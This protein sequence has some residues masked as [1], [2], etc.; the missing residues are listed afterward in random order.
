MIAKKSIR[1]ALF[2]LSFFATVYAAHAQVR[3]V[4]SI[5]PV[6]SLVS[7]VMQ[8][9]G[10]PEL[11]V[12]G[13]GSPHAYA[14]RP[15][16]ASAMQKAQVV[17]W[18]SEN[19]ER[20]LEGPIK[21]LAGRARVVELA[22]APGVTTRT[23]REGGIWEKHGHKEA[24]HRKAA[25]GKDNDHD[26]HDHGRIDSHMWVDPVN[27]KAYVTAI[28]A[29]LAAAD[30]GNAALYR[31]N[32]TAVQAR[33]DALQSEM[34]ATLAPVKAKGFIVFHDAFQYLEKRFGLKGVGS[35]SLG[36]ARAPGAR[37]LRD[38][39]SRLKASG[40]VCVFS[41]P[42]FEPRL[43]QTVIEGMP[44]KTG[45]LDP[46]GAALG[47]GPDLYFMMMRNNARALRA[48]LAS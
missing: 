1:T 14:M 48:C 46:L 25:H 10:K 32:A 30:P 24:A 27:A 19:L 7:A 29:A 26:G 15:S 38:I 12:Q 8:G 16:D 4:A 44:I 31:K 20:F 39:R 34:S 11:I 37:R 47:N 3:V 43:V 33:L 13:G 6:H 28:A 22:E 2:S 35:I 21:A 45:V 5:K 9:A 41:E 42:Q 17:F 40:A 23:I 18:V 36:D